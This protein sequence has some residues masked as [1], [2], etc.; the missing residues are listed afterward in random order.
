M[1]KGTAILPSRGEG[2]W[3]PY[4]KATPYGASSIWIPHEERIKIRWN[5]TLNHPH[6]QKPL[7]S[8]VRRAQ[9][10][11]GKH[12]RMCEERSKKGN[13]GRKKEPE[14][15]LKLFPQR[16]KKNFETLLH[17]RRRGLPGLSFG[18]AV[19]YQKGSGG[20]V[21]KSRLWRF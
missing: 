6:S 19:L 11:G 14:G 8:S 15:A 13:Q 5:S 12:H 3:P 9:R 10:K 4:R 18:K 2:V 7:P 16:K 1:R 17:L 21:N 20:E